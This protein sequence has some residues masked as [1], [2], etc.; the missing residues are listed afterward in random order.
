MKI[1]IGSLCTSLPV[2]DPRLSSTT[3]IFSTCAHDPRFPSLAGKTAIKYKTLHFAL[4]SP[5]LPAKNRKC[6]K[7]ESEKRPLLYQRPRPVVTL[8]SFPLPPSARNKLATFLKRGRSATSEI[9]A[10]K[11]AAV[12]QPFPPIYFLF[13]SS[14]AASSFGAKKVG[15]LSLLN[16]M[17]EAL[18]PP[19]R[20]SLLLQ[21]YPTSL[22]CHDFLASPFLSPLS[23]AD[24]S[25]G[26]FGEGKEEERAVKGES[27]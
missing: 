27:V 24:P 14:L 2:L 12:L 11:K 17:E 9:Y 3:P 25:H 26:R 6:N 19:S 18:S 21:I 10:W 5:S 4:P 16:K 22:L 23:R 7:T 15:G 8:L 13:S 1:Y 20:L